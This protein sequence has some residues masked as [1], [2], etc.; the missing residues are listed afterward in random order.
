MIYDCMSSLTDNNMNIVPVNSSWHLIFTGWFK[1]Y[2]TSNTQ[3]P[4]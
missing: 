4:M 1:C 3:I 2:V